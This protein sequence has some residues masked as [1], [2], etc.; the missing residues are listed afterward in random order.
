MQIIWCA[1]DRKGLWGVECILAVIGA[2]GPVKC[3]NIILTMDQ[4]DAGS[5]GIFSRR[6]NDI[7]CDMP[8]SPHS[9]PPSFIRALLATLKQH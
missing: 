1:S 8:R 6:T 3:S 9:R 4:S 2:G 7:G 5:T